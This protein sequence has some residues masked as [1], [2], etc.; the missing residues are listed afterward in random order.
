MAEIIDGTAVAAAVRAEVAQDAAA[1]QR[2]HGRRPALRVVLVG[3]HAASQSYVR[4]K[5]RAAGE[6]GIDAETLAR[7]ADL[8]ER[9]L[10]ALIARLN[11]DD[12]VDGIL[13][14][15]PLPDHVDEG[16]VIRAVDPAKDVD[17]F[18]PENVGR[19][20]L[21]EPTLE[22]CTPAGIVELLRR[23]GVETS[24]AHAV[25]LGRSN[26]VGKPLASLLLRRGLDATVTVCHSRT[27]DLPALARQA[28]VLVAAIGRAGFV[29]ADMVKP[30][31][32]VVDVG[33]NRVDDASRERGYRLVGDVDFDAVADVAGAITP[34]PGGVGPM[35]IAMLLA[36]TVEAARRRAAV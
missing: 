6:A 32:A 12:G 29:T 15:L 11:A 10:L 27:R 35:T 7:P 33:I 26:I 30:G 36:N 5:A 20:V 9:D 4:A 8:S 3:E 19:L 13:V 23:T 1:F 17:G 16:A 25:V 2:E 21:G 22:P 28:D 31:A 14:Q 34:V 24:G 18:H